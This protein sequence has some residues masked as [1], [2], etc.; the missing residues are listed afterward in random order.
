MSDSRLHHWFS[1]I[2]KYPGN[3]YPWISYQVYLNLSVVSCISGSN[4]AFT[5]LLL[6]RLI[7]AGILLVS[8]HS[9]E[10][11]A[12]TASHQDKRTLLSDIRPVEVRP[13]GGLRPGMV[14]I[15]IFCSMTDLGHPRPEDCIIA[16][17]KIQDDIDRVTGSSRGMSALYAHEFLGVGVQDASTRYPTVDTPKIYSFGAQDVNMQRFVLLLTDLR[18]VLA[19]SVS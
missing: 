7:Y 10:H 8:S 19:S 4:M 11:A 1:I 2:R 13:Q 14:I 12:L 17:G 16:Q 6:Y 5:F 9:I 18:Q 15:Q 3:I